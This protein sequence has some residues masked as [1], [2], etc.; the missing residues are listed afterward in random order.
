[1]GREE[2]EAF[3]TDL[4]VHG[5]VAPA[6]QNQALN[7]LVFLYRQV[8]VKPIEGINAVRAKDKQRLPVVL[9]KDEVKRLLLPMQGELA[10]VAG[11]LYG[12]GLRVMECL[13]LRVKDVDLDGGVVSA[14][15][16]KGRKSRALSF[17]ERLRGPMESQLAR[18]R[19]WHEADREA[20]L[21]GVYMP[22][23]LDRKAQD[24]GKRWEWFWI[25]PSKVI[26]VDPRGVSVSDGGESEGSVRRRHHL[27]DVTASRALRRAVPAAKI[28]KHVTAHT[29]R[30]ACS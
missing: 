9:T 17:P 18:I 14:H 25:F 30:E 19:A 23:A 3:L 6:T 4:A 5:N 15:D 13:R 20:N 10:L 16:A 29:L 24:W 28:P 11:L 26:A 22:G 21:A 8:L 7:A 2:V 12:C 27:K 1:M